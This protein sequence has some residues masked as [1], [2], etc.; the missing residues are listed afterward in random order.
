MRKT[1]LLVLVLVGCFLAVLG[2]AGC[3]SP[4][5]PGVPEVGQ[6]S[7]DRA[8]CRADPGMLCFSPPGNATRTARCDLPVVPCAPAPD[9]VCP[10]HHVCAFS[11]EL[12]PGPT[13]ILTCVLDHIP[14]N[15]S[16]FG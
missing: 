8:D 5:E 13:P 15:G 4:T 6:Q 7:Q 11:I 3:R 16:P 14:G 10:R 1:P 2:S 9:F 12:T